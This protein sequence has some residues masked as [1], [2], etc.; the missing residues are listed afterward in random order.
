MHGYLDLLKSLKGEGVNFVIVGGFAMIL[1]GA[2]TVTYD[3]DLAIALDSV[4]GAA[5]IK[6]LRPFRPYPPQLESAKHFV[7]DERSLFG[8]V[9]SLATDVGHVDILRVLPEIDNFEGLYERSEVRHFWGDQF[10]IASIDDLILLKQAAN[11]PKDRE[12]IRQLEVLKK[13][14]NE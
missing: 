7:W 3:L 13:I 11:R 8:A 14:R 10:R 1:H 4:N 6:A 2:S 9:I 12:H 5:V